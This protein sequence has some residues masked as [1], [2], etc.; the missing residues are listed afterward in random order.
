MNHRSGAH[1]PAIIPFDGFPIARDHVVRG[2]RS[3]IDPNRNAY[4]RTSLARGSEIVP[5]TSRLCFMNRFLDGIEPGG[6][7]IR[8]E[9][10]SLVTALG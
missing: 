3:T 5:T 2:L 4:P 1:E 10:D 9:V 8:S 7:P 6:S